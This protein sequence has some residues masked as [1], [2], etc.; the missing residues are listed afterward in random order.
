M[1]LGPRNMVNLTVF[2]AF[3]T[4]KDVVYMEFMVNL[5]VESQCRPLRFWNQAM[6]F[7]PADGL[8]LDLGR[9]CLTIGLSNIKP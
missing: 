4:G 9:E 3:L 1:P 5:I 7:I 6:A 2:R 8:L